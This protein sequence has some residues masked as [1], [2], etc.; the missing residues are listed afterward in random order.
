MTHG[1]QHADGAW[2]GRPLKR[3]E[4]HRLLVGAGRYVDDISPHGCAHVALLRSPHA[5]ARIARLD[6]EAA[7]R[8]PGVVAVVTCVDVYNLQPITC[9]FVRPGAGRPCAC[10][11][12]RSS[13]TGASTPQARPWPPWWRTV[14]MPRAT[15]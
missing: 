10:R 11:P 3:R 13:P 6:V 14:S 4:D 15:P 5:H 8:G 7:R 1:A 2:I 12:I 9:P